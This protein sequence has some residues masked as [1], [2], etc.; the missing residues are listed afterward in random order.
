MG[1]PTIHSL[2]SFAT[3]R[4]LKSCDS[5]IKAVSELGFVQADPIRAPARAQDLI[6]RQRVQGYRAGDLEQQYPRLP[7][8][9]DVLHVYGFLP[10]QHRQLLHPRPLGGHWQQFLDAHASLRKSVL[11]FVQEQGT[12]HPRTVEKEFGSDTC[13]NGWGGRS[14]QTTMMLEALHLQGVLRIARRESGQ[15]V[16]EC[17]DRQGR[18][19]PLPDHK[20]AEGLCRLIVGLYS[21]MPLRSLRQVLGAVRGPVTVTTKDAIERLLVSGELRRERIDSEDWIWFYDETA[22]LL[23]AEGAEDR[24]RLLA[25]FDPVVW[26]RRRFALL[27]NWEYRFEAYTPVGK[28]KLGY[29]ALPLLYRDQV[30]GAANLSVREGTLDAELR[31]VGHRPQ[32]VAFRRGLKQELSSFQEF[33]GL[34]PQTP[35]E[36]LE[37]GIAAG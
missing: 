23:A 17:A 25:P 8:S 15:R 37:S 2:R 27:W 21:P 29:Y 24:V 14:S 11:R 9:E 5:I 3:T 6:L 1:I 7:L 34:C 35:C 22:E 4:S 33:L 12:V 32:E 10:S 13:E 20:R 28:R 16:Y 36:P 19:R 31:F 26:D 30:I 18:Q